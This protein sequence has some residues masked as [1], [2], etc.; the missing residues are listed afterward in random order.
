[1]VVVHKGQFNKPVENFEVV[2]CIVA[3]EPVLQEL[4]FVL[5]T[6]HDSL[7]E[8]EKAPLRETWEKI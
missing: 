3:I 6:A 1:M 4:I 2:D 5:D 8:L 7:P